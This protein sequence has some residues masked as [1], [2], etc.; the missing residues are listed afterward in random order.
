MLTQRLR[1]LTTGRLHTK[2]DHVYQDIEYLTGEPGIMTHMIPNAMRALEPW[3]R[4]QVTDA[5]FWDDVHDV[6]HVGETDVAP[7][8]PTERAAFFERYRT[9]PSPLAGK[10]V[11]VVTVPDAPPAT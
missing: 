6:T 4:E 1:N 3:L 2:I 5:R 7:M 9:L 8:T 10:P 11:V